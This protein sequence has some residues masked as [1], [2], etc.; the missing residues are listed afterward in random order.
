LGITTGR[1]RDAHQPQD[2]VQGSSSHP[3]QFPG[4]FHK[5]ESSEEEESVDPQSPVIPRARAS[6]RSSPL[7][8][9]SASTPGEEEEGASSEESSSPTPGL[10]V[11]LLDS[12]ESKQNESGSTGNGSGSSSTETTTQSSSDR[13][14]NLLT[15]LMQEGGVRFLN[16]L[17]AKAVTPDSESLDISKVREWSY[18]DILHMHKVQ[19]K[20]WE[21]AC[22][23]ELDS[24]RARDV[25]DLV[26]PLSGRKIIK[27]RW[28][29]DI[30]T[31]GHKKA[32]LVAKRFSQVEGIDFNDIFSPVVRYKTVQLILTLAVLENWHMSSVDVKTAFL[33]GE[34]DKE[35]YM[36]QPEGFKIS[37]KEHL[38]L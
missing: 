13:V 7:S 31:D 37:G 26:N 1:L 27:N 19:Q 12:L 35:L 34:L 2:F 14:E 18:R 17:L 24:L 29:F 30:K 5:E 38:V 6:S 22:Q 16:Y 20:E 10:L 3:G 21:A 32:R 36:E 9:H 8:R 25:Y 33:Y 28:V 11:P 23:Q 4:G 15:T